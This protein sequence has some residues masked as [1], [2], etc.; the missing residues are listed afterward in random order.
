MNP[1]AL[2][3]KF[4]IKPAIRLSGGDTVLSDAA[5]TRSDQNQHPGLHDGHLR[6]P[7]DQRATRP[8]LSHPENRVEKTATYPCRAILNQESSSRYAVSYARWKIFLCD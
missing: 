6:R 2:A 3:I 8:A 4:V 5:D 1:F 7:A